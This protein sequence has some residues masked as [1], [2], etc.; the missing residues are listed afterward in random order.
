MLPAYLP[1]SV[2]ITGLEGMKQ[3]NMKILSYGKLKGTAVYIRRIVQCNGLLIVEHPLNHY[4]SGHTVD[5]GVEFHLTVCQLIDHALIALIH[6]QLIHDLIH[7]SE[8]CLH[9]TSCIF[10]ARCAAR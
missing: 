10:V 5:Q 8:N 4:V 7:L 1:R 6:F 9:L 3:I 2:G